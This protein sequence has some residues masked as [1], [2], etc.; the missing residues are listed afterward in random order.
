LRFSEEGEELLELPLRNSM[1]E[2]SRRLEESMEHETAPLACHTTS[3]PPPAIV[4]SPWWAWPMLALSVCAVSSA[5]AAF[6]SFHDQHVP[7]VLLASWRL[8]VC[9]L[10]FSLSTVS[11]VLCQDSRSSTLHH[12]GHV[13]ESRE[14]GRASAFDC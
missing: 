14:P 6:K 5:G 7:P 12:L 4:R 10:S 1:E 2:E 8:Q 13:S 9:A 3:P 11:L